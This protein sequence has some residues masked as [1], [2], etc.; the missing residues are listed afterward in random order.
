MSETL[1]MLSF[2]IQSD[3]ATLWEGEKK[4]PNMHLFGVEEEKRK[5]KGKEM[6]NNGRHFTSTRSL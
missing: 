2:N 4:V 5:K 6:S 1:K 3:S